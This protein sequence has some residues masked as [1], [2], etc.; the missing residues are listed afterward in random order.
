VKKPPTFPYVTDTEMPE[1]L[2]AL[3]DSNPRTA[4][5]ETVSNVV[6]DGQGADSGGISGPLRTGT[7]TGRHRVDSAPTYK[8]QHPQTAGA[9]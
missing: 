2:W 9:A 5:Y 7:D 4:D 6:P 3:W 8:S 1:T